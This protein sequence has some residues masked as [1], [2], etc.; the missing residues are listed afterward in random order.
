MTYNEPRNEISY[1]ILSNIYI[2]VPAAKMQFFAQS[3]KVREYYYYMLF[4]VGLYVYHEIVSAMFE[5]KYLQ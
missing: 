1:N 5:M 2:P 4:S 3:S